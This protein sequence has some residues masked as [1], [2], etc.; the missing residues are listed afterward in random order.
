[1]DCPVRSMQPHPLSELHVRSAVPPPETADHK[2]SRFEGDEE[3]VGEVI[4]VVGDWL[5]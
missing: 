5:A 2:F 3:D 4:G 1:M